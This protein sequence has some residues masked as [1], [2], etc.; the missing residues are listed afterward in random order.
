M[1]FRDIDHGDA[2]KLL[3]AP[4]QA[5]YLKLRD[6]ERRA[7]AAGGQIPDADAIWMASDKGETPE[8]RRDRLELMWA[9]RG[10][11]RSPSWAEVTR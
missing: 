6:I 11:G 2:W 5:A 4:S 7:R 10:R 3:S 9:E 1:T 8:E